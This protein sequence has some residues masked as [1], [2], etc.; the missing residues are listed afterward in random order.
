[1]NPIE[2]KLHGYGVFPQLNIS[3]PCPAIWEFCEEYEDYE[4][5]SSLT[6]DYLTNVNQLLTEKSTYEKSISKVTKKWLKENGWVI[7]NYNVSI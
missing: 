6:K 1:M 3:A 4:A 2:I 5:I 7:V